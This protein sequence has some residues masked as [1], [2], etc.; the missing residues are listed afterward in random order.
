MNPIRKI[1]CKWELGIP[2]CDNYNHVVSFKDFNRLE[3]ELKKY[4]LKTKKEN[5]MKN[6][7]NLD[8]KKIEISEETA[9]NLRN[10]INN[11]IPR[12]KEDSKYYY[13][14]YKVSAHSCVEQKYGTDDESY[15][16]GNYFI[17]KNDAE[18]VAKKFKEILDEFHKNKD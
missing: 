2:R 14:D 6:Y 13:V 7:I 15:N 10:E 11:K 16:S 9:D 1:I 12:A 17:N 18:K 5:K 3:E 4:M 8:G